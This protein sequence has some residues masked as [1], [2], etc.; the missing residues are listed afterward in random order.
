MSTRIMNARQPEAQHSSPK[1]F[2]DLT[3]DIIGRICDYLA[4]AEF[5]PRPFEYEEIKASTHNRKVSGWDDFTFDFGL[6][7]A[8]EQDYTLIAHRSDEDRTFPVLKRSATTRKRRRNH[9]AKF[10]ATCSSVAAAAKRLKLRRNFLLTVS[11]H[12]ITFEGLRSGLPWQTFRAPNGSAMIDSKRL[13]L[14][15]I[16][17]GELPGNRAFEAFCNILTKI[18]RLRIHIAADLDWLEA[19]KLNLFVH[20]INYT[21]LSVS[22]R[23]KQLPSIELTL[24]VGFH[25]FFAT[26]RRGPFVTL[27]TKGPARLPVH[28]AQH[29]LTLPL[30]QRNV[31]STTIPALVPTLRTILLTLS[32]SRHI[33]STIRDSD[34]HP[35]A[36]KVLIHGDG[37][38]R[39]F[40]GKVLSLRLPF[41]TI[42]WF[43]ERL[44]KVE[45]GTFEEFCCLLQE[46]VFDSTPCGGNDILDSERKVCRLGLPRYLEGVDTTTVKDTARKRKSDGDGD[47]A[48]HEGDR[49]SQRPRVA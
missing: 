24:D 20:Q 1:H 17:L 48:Q 22:N 14:N 21:I 16:E 3:E 36:F 34:R 7:Q 12:G 23:R 19:R 46:K 32:R 37:L 30:N 38:G 39:T 15:S 11:N 43:P 5:E 4:P 44:V 45:Y 18:H 8:T 6:E 49:S 10:A 26:R 31:A 9:L 2:F 47:D 29:L 33:Q 42:Q 27:N 25:G 41:N 40:W 28:V 35:F 13:W